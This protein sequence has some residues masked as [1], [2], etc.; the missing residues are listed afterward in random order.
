M[1][2]A[3][4]VL[5]KAAVFLGVSERIEAQILTWVIYHLEEVGSE[6]VD[7]R[8]VTCVDGCVD[9]WRWFLDVSHDCHVAQR[10][11][12]TRMSQDIGHCKI[13]LQEVQQLSME[14]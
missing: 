2:E 5:W 13:L 11:E 12:R 8:A 4:N 1:L 14:L 6:A 3:T 10:C 9:G 7:G